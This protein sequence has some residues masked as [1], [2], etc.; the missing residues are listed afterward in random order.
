LTLPNR[1]RAILRLKTFGR[2]PWQ[3][4]RSKPAQF[5]Q[6]AQYGLGVEVDLVDL[7]RR[8]AAECEKKAQSLSVEMS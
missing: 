2:T 3:R 1:I 4:D 7:F 5:D 6:R 8:T